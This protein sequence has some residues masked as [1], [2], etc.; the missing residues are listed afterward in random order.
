MMQPENLTPKRAVPTEPYVA[1]ANPAK[2]AYHNASTKDDE[3][4]SR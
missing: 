1:R 4:W 3:E 2:A